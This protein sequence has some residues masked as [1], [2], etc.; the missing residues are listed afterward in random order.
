MD[1]KETASP[2]PLNEE[3]FCAQSDDTFDARREVERL[4]SGFVNTLV[5]DVRLPLASILGLLE[6]FESK[7]QARESFDMEDRQLLEAAIENGDR[8]RHLLDD[9]LEIGHGRERPLAI[10]L[11]EV[12]VE[13]LLEQ[14]TEPLRGEAALR[15]VELNVSVP[16]QS[17]QMLVDAK[18][19]RRA[20]C[21]LLT[22]ALAATPDGG[23]VNVEAQAIMGTRAGDEGKRLVLINVADSG[24]GIP[25]EEVPFMFDAFWQAADSPQR[26]GRGV[27]LSIARRIAA[28]HGGNVTVRSQLGSGTIFSM[29]LPVNLKEDAPD[30]RRILI[31]EDVPEILLLQRKLVARMGYEVEIAPDAR[32]ALAL[33]ETKSFDL[34]I[35]D[36]AMPGMSGGELISAVK[37]DERLREIPVI[38]LT[39]HDADTER[40]EAKEAGCARFLVKPFKRDELQKVI[41]ELLTVTVAAT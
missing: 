39:G 38:V 20:V 4:K 17:L 41:A 26:M 1:S 14:V 15:G 8:I 7:L 16:D 28:A 12:A 13:T 2:A 23:T 31:V 40:E 34:L 30:K 5:R 19:T 3:V 18:Q 24:A 11:E 21:H 29:V 35:T 33:L 32:Q 6:L 25:A 36:W 10:E 37:S 27:G 22:A 9:L